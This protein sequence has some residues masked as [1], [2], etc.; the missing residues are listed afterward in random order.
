MYSK[1][2]HPMYIGIILFHIGYP[3]IF[4]SLVALLSSILWAA[5]IFAWKVFEERNLERQFGEKYIEYKKRT[6]F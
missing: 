5:F 4:K 2:R 1:I 6:W 3:L